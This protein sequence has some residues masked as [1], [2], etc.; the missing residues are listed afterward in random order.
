MS[1]VK[2]RRRTS[3]DYFGTFDVRSVSDMIA[4]DDLKKTVKNLN[5]RFKREGVVTQNGT[6]VRYRVVLK[7]RRPFQK[8]INPRTG[9]PMSY[10]WDGSVVGGISNASQ[11]DAYIHRR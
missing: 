8:H 5:A 9:R 4:L 7:G 6:P 1:N 10:N 3:Q 2:P 11:L